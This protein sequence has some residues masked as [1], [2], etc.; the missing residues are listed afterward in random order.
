MRSRPV[1]CFDALVRLVELGA[2]LRDLALELAAGS[3]DV[4]LEVGAVLGRDAA[5]ARAGGGIPPRQRRIRG[6]IAARDVTG[7]VG[8]G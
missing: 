8:H 3:A 7:C 5:P 2:G 6:R 1:R 4:R